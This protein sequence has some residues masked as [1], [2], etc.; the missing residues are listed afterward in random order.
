[1][2]K[3]CSV[4]STATLRHR[5]TLLAWSL[6]AP[7]PSQ[8]RSLASKNTI[9]ISLVPNLC[10]NKDHFW[11]LLANT[12]KVEIL[13]KEDKPQRYAAILG[14]K[15]SGLTTNLV[16]AAGIE[17][18]S[19]NSLLSALH[20]YSVFKFN[21]LLPDRQ[22][23]QTAVLVSFSGSVPDVLFSRSYVSDPWDLEA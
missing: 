18:A 21:R 5:L 9:E 3:S 4:T 15:W 16:E 8:Q 14:L 2:T 11:L 12:G 10:H 6:A 13:E 22:G 19:A 23:S 17:P 7:L 1:M 20:A